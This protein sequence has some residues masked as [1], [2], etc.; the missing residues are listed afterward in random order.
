M[1]NP[2]NAELLSKAGDKYSIVILT[3]KRARELIEGAKPMVETSSTKP[4]TIAMEEIIQDM[5]TFEKPKIE[6]IK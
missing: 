2:S 3:A 1:Y 5:L 4:V 6:S